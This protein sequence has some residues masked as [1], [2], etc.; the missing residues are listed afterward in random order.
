MFDASLNPSLEGSGGFSMIEESRSGGGCME[1]RVVHAAEREVAEAD[2][3]SGVVREQAVAGD[4]VWAGLVRTAPGR[5]SGWHHHGDYNTYFYVAAGKVRMEFGPG[6]ADVVEGGPGDFVHVPKGVVHREVNPDDE[7]G[8]LI[9]VRVG[10]G[11][12]V[13]NVEGPPPIA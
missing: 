4:G 2:A 8:T 9:L 13:V 1:I 6:G 10:S 5:S 7:E 12:P 11:P 3:T